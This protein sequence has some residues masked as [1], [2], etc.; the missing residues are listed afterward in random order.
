MTDSLCG[1][2]LDIFSVFLCAAST[3]ESGMQALEW[4]LESL[5]Q[6]GD[7]FVVCRAVEEDALDKDHSVL[8]D[9]ARELMK[10][11]EDKSVEYE[12]DRKVYP[13]IYDMC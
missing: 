8:R 13:C 7:E 3:D 1:M 9:E 10:Q 2:S 4:A 5:V 11:I 6:D 12:P